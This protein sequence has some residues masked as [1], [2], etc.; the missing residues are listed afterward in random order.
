MYQYYN[1]YILDD[2]NKILEVLCQSND[3]NGSNN[4][5]DDDDDD[6]D[7]VVLIERSY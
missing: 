2:M 1:E 6:N 3:D 7:N 4:D 5:D